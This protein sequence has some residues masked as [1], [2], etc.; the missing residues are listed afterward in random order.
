MQIQLLIYLAVWG[1]LAAF[2]LCLLA[3]AKRKVPI[4]I[5]EA[6]VL[7]K[8]HKQ[9]TNCNR[10]KWEPLSERNGKI[11]G[12]KCECGHQYSQR[13]HFLSSKPKGLQ[14]QEK[15]HV[16]SAKSIAKFYAS[17]NQLEEPEPRVNP[18][19]TRAN[20]KSPLK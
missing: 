16:T 4:S 10:H 9:D 15:I 1:A 18:N 7:W 14:M 6:K 19:R 13:G 3:I 20:R 17:A 8:I 12:F 11:T 2:G 5:E